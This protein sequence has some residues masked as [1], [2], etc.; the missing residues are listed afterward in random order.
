[1]T[2]VILTNK[3][4]GQEL[5]EAEVVWKTSKSIEIRFDGTTFT[6][7]FPIKEWDVR[8]VRTFR[9]GDVLRRKDRSEH[10]VF[11]VYTESGWGYVNWDQRG[12]TLTRDEPSIYLNNPE[13]ELV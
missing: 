5:P 2:R 7:S 13:W 10:F 8:E 4:T 9:N 3:E 11:Y 6:N 1:M 12:L